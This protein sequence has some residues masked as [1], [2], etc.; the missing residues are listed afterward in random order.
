MGQYFAIRDI[1]ASED[2]WFSGPRVY[3]ETEAFLRDCSVDFE[4]GIF[5][6][7]PVVGNDWGPYYRPED[8][9]PPEQGIS[10]TEAAREME[11]IIARIDDLDTVLPDSPEMRGRREFFEMLHEIFAKAPDH[12]FRG[13]IIF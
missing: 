2:I 10:G 7:A 9:K 11:F 5:H 3:R 6:D 4:R 8:D 12:Q 1:T 13:Y